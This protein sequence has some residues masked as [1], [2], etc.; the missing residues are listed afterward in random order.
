MQGVYKYNLES[1][2]FQL[3]FKLS[4][5]SNTTLFKTSKGE[6][7]LITGKNG[8]FKCRKKDFE[9]WSKIEEEGIDSWSVTDR[10]EYDGQV[11]YIDQGSN[12][13][14]FDIN[15]YMIKGLKLNLLEFQICFLFLVSNSV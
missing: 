3:L 10:V 11:S 14:S 2:S 13:N 5:I 12:L 4:C 15:S 9:N 6:V 1:D 8:V 7:I